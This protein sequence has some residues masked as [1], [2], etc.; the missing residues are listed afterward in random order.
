MSSSLNSALGEL[1]VPMPTTPPSEP[2][3]LHLYINKRTISLQVDWGDVGGLATLHE[4]CFTQADVQQMPA[5][6]NM[7]S[8]RRPA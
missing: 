1:C 7:M 4:K 8:P 6:I 5:V 3:F 2:E